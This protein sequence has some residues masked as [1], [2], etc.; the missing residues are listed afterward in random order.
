MKFYDERPEKRG[1]LIVVD[2]TMRA[3]AVFNKGYFETEDETIINKLK[4][5]GYKSDEEPIKEVKT[6]ASK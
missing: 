2:E 4:S 5:L 3:I 6:K 1:S